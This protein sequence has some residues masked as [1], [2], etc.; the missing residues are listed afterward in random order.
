MADAEYRHS[1]YK[2]KYDERLEKGLC[3]YCGKV[4]ALPGFRYCEKCRDRRKANAK[5]ARER[6]DSWIPAKWPTGWCY[7]CGGQAPKGR[8]L[9]E[10]HMVQ[11]SAT[12]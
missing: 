1:Y 2:K 10:V 4:D 11:R 7:I 6:A 3:V 9:C 12:I 8:K 5:R